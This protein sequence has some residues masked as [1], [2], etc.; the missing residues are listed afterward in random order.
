MFVRDKLKK[1]Q[2]GRAWIRR[3]LYEKGVSSHIVEKVFKEY[4]SDDDQE[5]AAHLAAEKRLRL[6]NATF[7]KLDNDRKRKRLF[8]YLLRRGF[9]S[10]VAL[11]AVRAVLA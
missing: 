5:Q 8:D 10:D 2:V 4:I 11:K 3:A 1:K 9:S 7:E 6:A